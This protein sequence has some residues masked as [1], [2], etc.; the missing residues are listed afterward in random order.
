MDSKR[1]KAYYRKCYKQPRGY[2]TLSPTVYKEVVSIIERYPEEVRTITLIEN[3]NEL[4]ITEKDI[5]DKVVCERNIKT[6][7]DTLIEWVAEEHRAMIWENIETN[8][9][10]N[11]LAYKHHVDPST[12][13]LIWKKYLYG[14]HINLG[15]DYLH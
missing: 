4:D 6:L 5:A 2:Y 3:K 1:E 10:W 7:K 14:L 15:L 12:A 13:K 11:Y 9:T 8:C